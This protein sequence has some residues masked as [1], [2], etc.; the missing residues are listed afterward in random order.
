METLD[1]WVVVSGAADRL[2]VSKARVHQLIRAGALPASQP[3]RDLLIPLGALE[4]Y[5]HLRPPPGRPISQ[6]AAWREI[7]SVDLESIA[8][9]ETRD[10]WRRRVRARADWRRYRIHPAGLKRL[11]ASSA[12]VLSGRDA[13]AAR[14][15]P[16]DPDPDQ[17]IGYVTDTD[18]DTLVSELRLRHDPLHWN[19]ELG[20]IDA[21]NWPYGRILNHVS[22]KVCWLDLADH[23]DRAEDILRA[24][25]FSRPTNQQRVAEFRQGLVDRGARTVDELA[26]LRREQPA[27]TEKRLE[28]WLASDRIVVVDH[29]GE[30]LI[31][32]SLLDDQHEPDAFWRPIIA[33]LRKSGVAS[34]GIWSWIDA[35]TS[36]LSGQIPSDV[37]E[38]DPDR[39]QLALDHYL[40]SLTG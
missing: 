37:R 24:V 22:E 33:D 15:H 25:V 34:W 30:E 14:L 31:P 11:R 9:T 7:A 6:A 35:P 29:A 8:P 4:D 40:H 5:L 3:G 38:S 27:N 2:G 39:V 20:V 12:V 16:V 13:A 36:F 21:A 1:G 26:D 18:L 10:Q 28:E 17:V 23:R 19:V 32:A